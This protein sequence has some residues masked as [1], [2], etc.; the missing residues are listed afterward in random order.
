MFT[1]AD[2]KREYFVIYQI[3]NK[4]EFQSHGS[5]IFCNVKNKITVNYI[6]MLQ[7]AYDALLQ[8]YIQ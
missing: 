6:K 2:S 7:Q 4:T 3:K 1:F 5:Q 8:K